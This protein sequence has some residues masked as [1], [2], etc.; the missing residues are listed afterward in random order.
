MEV[1]TSSVGAMLG[2]ISSSADEVAAE[3]K[4]RER[5]QEDTSSASP[6]VATSPDDATKPT[7]DLS[8]FDNGN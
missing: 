5:Q 1:T 6:D 8:K 4:D 7:T 2:D 3:E